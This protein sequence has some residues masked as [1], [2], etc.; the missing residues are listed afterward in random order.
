MPFAERSVLAVF[1]GSATIV[2]ML[3]TCC[4]APLAMTCR[5]AFLASSALGLPACWCPDHFRNAFHIVGLVLIFG[6]S[7]SKYLRSFA[8]FTSLCS[9]ATGASSRGMGAPLYQRREKSNRTGRQNRLTNT[10]ARLQECLTP[11]SG[12][13]S[14]PTARRSSDAATGRRRTR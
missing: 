10:S 14:A 7:S 12:S 1:L 5:A 9:V 3:L 11:F 8:D 4:V 2:S 13:V 6:N